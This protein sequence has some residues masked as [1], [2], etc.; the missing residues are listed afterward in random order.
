MSI[1]SVIGAVLKFL[2][3]LFQKKIERDETKKKQMEEAANEVKTG[4]KKRDFSAITAG[5]ARIKRI[6]KRM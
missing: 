5:F 3:L 4:I 6:N 1:L 2:F